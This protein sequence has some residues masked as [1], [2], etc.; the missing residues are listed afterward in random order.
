MKLVCRLLF[1]FTLLIN[2]N[3]FAQDRYSVSGIV[4]DESGAIQKGA[5]VFISGS[6]KITSTDDNGRFEFS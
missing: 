1:I 6:Q 4:T 3:A 2:F 5:T